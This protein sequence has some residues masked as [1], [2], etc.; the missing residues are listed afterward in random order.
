MRFNKDSLKSIFVDHIE[1]VIFGFFVL[2]FL[3][4]IWGGFSLKPLSIST[5][6]LE[7]SIKRGRQKLEASEPDVSQYTSIDYEKEADL[8]AK[9]ISPKALSLLELN[10][11]FR[12]PS[13]QPQV[14][15]TQPPVL[16]VT[17]L[18]VSSGVGFSPEI[19]NDTS[20]SPRSGQNSGKTQQL[21]LNPG[22]RWVVVTALIPNLEQEKKFFE[23]FR[24]S[25]VKYP[26]SD[27]PTYYSYYVERRFARLE[28]A[29]RQGIRY[30]QQ[31]LQQRQRK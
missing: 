24:N 15:R 16:T 23:T 21:K 30:Y 7:D 4:M 2:G 14:K 28:T 27:R 13:A 6:Q 25:D 5:S 10:K 17:N 8:S 29:G 22:V 26:E 31:T 1:K 19:R 12:H 9:A 18:Q 3:F 20:V 11:D